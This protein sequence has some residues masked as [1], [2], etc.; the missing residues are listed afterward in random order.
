[1][2]AQVHILFVPTSSSYAQEVQGMEDR[3]LLLRRVGA[4]GAGAGGVGAACLSEKITLS[5]IY[6][7]IAIYKQYV[8]RETTLSQLLLASYIFNK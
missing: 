2:F 1:M 7:N 6:S 3:G 4:G 5:P 8:I